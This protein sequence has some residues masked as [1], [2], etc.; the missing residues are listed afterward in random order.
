MKVKICGAR[1]SGDGQMIEKAGA[2]FIGFVFAPS[3]RQVDIQTAHK[4]AKETKFIKKVGVFVNPSEEELRK[5]VEEVPLDYIQLHGDES[6]ELAG[7]FPGKV[8]KAFPSNSDRSFKEIFNYPAEYILMDSPRKEHY[9]GSG[10]VFDWEQLDNNDIQKNR[11]FLAGGLKAGN[12]N[13]A[14]ESAQPFAVDVSSG[15]E[16]DGRK[17]PVKVKEFMENV[18]RETNV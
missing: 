5:T 9:G 13:E 18:R 11:L 15:V 17:D 6:P 7:L 10:Q 3:K 14:I 4:I 1:F 12:I 2:D 16:T 8:I